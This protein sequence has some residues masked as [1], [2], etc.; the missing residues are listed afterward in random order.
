MLKSLYRSPSDMGGGAESEDEAGQPQDQQPQGQLLDE[1]GQPVKHDQKGGK[2]GNAPEDKKRSKKPLIILGIVILVLA[3]VALIFWFLGRNHESTDDAYTE[4]NAI[5]I[6]P[7]ISGYVVE[8]DINDNSFVHAGDVMLRIDPRDYI[9]ARDSAAATLELTRAQLVGAEAAYD[10]AK[11]SVP[12]KLVQA[13][14]QKEA[15][16]ASQFQARQEAKRQQSVEQRATTLQNID[17]ATAQA[18]SAASQVEYN[19]AQ[20]NIAKLI[21]QN[22]QQA[23]AQVKQLE[24]Q[25]KQAEANLAQAELNLSYTEVRAPQDG[26]V[27]RRN[28]QLGSYAQPGTGIFT[29]VTTDV[30]V[31]ANFKETQLDRMRPGQRVEI[32]CDSY[33]SLHLK[34][35]VQSIQMGSGSRFSTFPAENATGNFVKIVQRVPVKLVIDGGLD[36][37]IPLPL[38]LSVEPTVYLK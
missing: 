2:N 37:K 24:G 7:K 29:L 23:A 28:V 10:I 3:I 15:A 11:V 38:G 30:W 19:Q 9:N 13:E 18:K 35:Y 5:A 8:L 16:E 1:H 22:L 20:V 25:V 6:A 27:T 4:G 26:W 21:P 33:P 17:N 31:V 14:A 36:P 32:S 34:G 12:A